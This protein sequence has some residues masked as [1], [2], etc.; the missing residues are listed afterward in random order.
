MADPIAINYVPVGAE[1]STNQMYEGKLQMT[2]VWT[3]SDNEKV[4]V[5]FVMFGHDHSMVRE[6][7]YVLQLTEDDDPLK[8]QLTAL[9]TTIIGLL[10]KDGQQL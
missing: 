10:M 9:Q 2:K 5:T 4:H 3:E 6:Q 8:T 7:T 1:N